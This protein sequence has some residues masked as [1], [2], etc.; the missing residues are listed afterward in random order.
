GGWLENFIYEKI[1]DL[2]KKEENSRFQ[3]FCK[4]HIDVEATYRAQKTNLERRTQIDNILM[5]GYQLM[6]IS[7]TTSSLLER[8]KLKT[9]EVLFRANQLAGMHSKAIIISFLE[10][11]DL[12]KLKPYFSLYIHE[13]RLS[14][15]GIDYIK[16]ILDEKKSMKNQ[17]INDLTGTRM[18]SQTDDINSSDIDHMNRET[19]SNNSKNVLILIIGKNPL[20]NLIA[21]T[22]INENSINGLP[23]PQIIFLLHST[24]TEK[25]AHKIEGMLNPEELDIVLI[26]IKDQIRKLNYVKRQLQNYLDKIKQIDSIH[27]NFTGGTKPMSLGAYLAISASQYN[28]IILSDIDPNLNKLRFKIRDEAIQKYPVGKKNIKDLRDVVHLSFNQILDLHNF[29]ENEIVK[30]QGKDNL[31]NS[32]N[33][34]VNTFK[35]TDILGPFKFQALPINNLLITVIIGYQLYLFYF[36]KKKTLGNIKKEAFEAQ[37]LSNMLGGDHA[38][39]IIIAD[40]ESHK[41][42]KLYGDLSEFRAI[43]N[44]VVINSLNLNLLYNNLQTIFTENDINFLW[45]KLLQ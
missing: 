4:L 16:N 9:F 1:K 17:L 2:L 3:E 18:S 23:K 36:S 13:N 29:N 26:S 22:I 42:N 30:V 31:I 6:F 11:E 44:C 5:K 8:V 33:G 20:P 43:Q 25:Y 15:F 35:H 19:I 45:G 38:K 28:N 37:S 41:L 7:L 32:I 39:T 12:N 34:A 21:A 27:L 24:T 40:I 14:M 10:E